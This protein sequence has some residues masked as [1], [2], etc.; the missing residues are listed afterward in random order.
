MP[1]KETKN[2]HLKDL[3]R[4]L[5]LEVFNHKNGELTFQDD[6]ENFG[7]DSNSFWK[8]TITLLMG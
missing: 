6:E 1:K 7:I 4:Y 3:V 8:T 2:V 5:H